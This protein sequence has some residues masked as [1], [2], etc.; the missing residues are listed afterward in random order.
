MKK[1]IAMMLALMMV[2]AMAAC[3]AEE[4][5]PA[6]TSAAEMTEAAETTAAT[7]AVLE[8]VPVE[9]PESLMVDGVVGSYVDQIMDYEYIN[10]TMELV[11]DD[12]VK[13]NLYQ[14]YL[15]CAADIKALEPGHILVLGDRQVV[16]EEVC[17]EIYEGEDEEGANITINPNG[18]QLQLLRRS[19]N[20]VWGDY[21]VLDVANGYTTVYCNTYTL[22][23]N[24]AN[25]IYSKMSAAGMEELTGA[26]LVQDLK[27]YAEAFDVN[28]T[29]VTFVNGVIEYVTVM[30]Y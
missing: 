15:F 10:V 2:L 14:P 30:V 13:F 11:D 16:V 12:T 1:M 3:G 19:M 29:A 21:S 27:E 7:Q 28:R 20:G 26:D 5:A 25:L 9:I 8:T 17:A 23:C 22:E 4:S 6:T 18:D 24:V